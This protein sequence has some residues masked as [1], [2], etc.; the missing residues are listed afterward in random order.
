[1]FKCASSSVIGMRRS[2]LLSAVFATTLVASC[3]AP[4]PAAAPPPRVTSAPPLTAP[5]QDDI[6]LTDQLQAVATVDLVARVPGFLREVDFSDGADV[7]K[8][9]VLFRIEDEPYA[10]QV[11]L[12]R[13]NLDQQQAT[14]KSAEAEFSRQDALRKQYVATQTSYDSALAARDTERGAVTAA[15][16]NLTTAQINLSYTKIAAPFAGRMG[17]RLVD[18]GNLV[19]AGTP[20]KL[21]TLS[22]ID[23]L[24]ATVTINERDLRRLQAAVRERGLTREALRRVPVRADLSDEPELPH[25]GHLDFVDSGLDAATGTLQARAVLDNTERRLAPGLFVRV[26]IP[27]GPPKPALWVPAEAVAVDQGGPTLLVVDEAG[28]VALRRVELG[29]AREGLRVIAAG[30]L[31]SDRV[32][33]EGLQHAVPGRGVATS[34]GAIAAPAAFARAE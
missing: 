32:I 15:Q 16:A 28:T 23:R 26:R 24:Y 13:A 6:G 11:A 20:T 25:S 14:L 21:G 7:Q 5:V 10:A 12:A 29:P 4:S 34:P 17:R 3:D 22:Q 33:T 30:L 18:P 2:A 31:A 1:M 9:Q 19:G 8:G 27:L